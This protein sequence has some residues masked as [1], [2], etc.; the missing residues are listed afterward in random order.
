M[1]VNARVVTPSGK[2]TGGEGGGSLRKMFQRKKSA[3]AASG[4]PTSQEIPR[5]LVTEGLN[6]EGEGTAM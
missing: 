6:H 4:R 2:R 5:F 3:A 1:P